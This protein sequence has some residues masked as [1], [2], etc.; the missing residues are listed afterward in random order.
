VPLPDRLARINRRL[1]N[2]VVR[3]IAGRFPTLA[4]VV[5]RGRATGQEYRT[6]VNAFRADALF[7]IALTYGANRDWVKNV[8]AGGGC[9]LERLGRRTPLT[10]P[11]IRRGPDARQMLPAPVRP[12]LRLL[13]VTEVL[14]LSPVEGSTQ[15][16]A[17]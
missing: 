3:S 6:P 5:H 1:T 10:D 7:A 14:T 12:V 2:P 16:G 13:G 8:V 9:T 15:R 4:I 17:S 11:H